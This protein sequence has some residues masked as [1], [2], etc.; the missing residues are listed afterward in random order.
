MGVSLGNWG[1]SYQLTKNTQKY[2][3]ALMAQDRFKRL[4]IGHDS[5]L[6]FQKKKKISLLVPNQ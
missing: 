6:N 3:F 5:S 4:G 1:Q 2:V